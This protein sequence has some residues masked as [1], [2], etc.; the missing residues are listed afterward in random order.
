MS[1]IPSPTL[2]KD[3]FRSEPDPCGSNPL[4]RA[5]WSRTGYAVVLTAPMAICQIALF[6]GPLVFLIGL[7]FWLVRNFQLMPAFD[8]VNWI[9]MFEQPHFRGSFL[10]TLV[11]AGAAAVITSAVSFP[12]AYAMAFF[13]SAQRRRLVVFLLVTP[14]FTSYLVR[15]YAWQ[16][17][18]SD[19]G[20]VNGALGLIGVGPVPMLNTPF[21]TM[22][23]YLT[24]SLPLVVLIQYMALSMVDRNHI[25]AAHNLGCA[26]FRTV[27]KVTIPS[28]R[29]G[30]TIAALFCF[31]FSFGDFISPMYLGGG[32]APTL[33]MLIID[34][35]KAGQQW[36][37][38]AVVSIVMIAT[39][40]AVA[41]AATTYAYR[42][43]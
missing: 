35:T 5:R 14:F 38:A 30:L 4:A 26:P 1:T 20:I 43:R 17:F 21:G 34:A 32:T 25:E 7:S 28:A 22:V 2:G 41:I 16:T 39:L 10:R 13:L 29:A 27:F 8:T 12:A 15:V 36:P 3:G 40:M 31:I 9:R 18:L 42:R 24:L 11:Q 6:L 33:S 19:Q 23:G 37:R